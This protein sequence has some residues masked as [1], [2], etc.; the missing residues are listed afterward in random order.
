MNQRLTFRRYQQALEE[1]Q[2][3]GLRC[4]ACQTVTVPPQAVCRSCGGR[5]LEEKPIKKT[6]TL[7]TFTV[8]RV[9]AEGWNPPFIV[10]LVET[11]DG[12]WVMGNLEGVSPES[13]GM[14]LMGHRVCIDS[15]IVK[16]DLYAYGDMR[17]LVFRRI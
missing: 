16:G 7:K 13:A 6:G 2:L 9:A 1:G 17:S 3:L 14:E 8:I 5:Q 12:A 15:R 4:Q 10:A 11:D